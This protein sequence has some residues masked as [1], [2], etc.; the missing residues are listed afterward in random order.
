MD[1][2][3]N[4][5]GPLQSSMD[6]LNGGSA[7]LVTPVK[8]K[9]HEQ[10]LEIQHKHQTETHEPQQQ[11]EEQQH[12]LMSQNLEQQHQQRQQHQ[13]QPLPPQQQH[14][15][16][17]AQHQVQQHQQKQQH[18]QQPQRQ[19]QQQ[20]KLTSQHLKQQQQQQQPQ[21]QQQQQQQHDTMT[22]Q[23]EQ[24]HQQQ[25]QPQQQQQQQQQHDTM[26][27]QL[28]QQQQQQQQQQKQQQQWQQ[29]KQQQQQQRQLMSGASSDDICSHQ[30]F[31]QWGMS[32]RLTRE[33]MHMLVKQGFHSQESLRLLTPEVM[34]RVGNLPLEQE[35]RLKQVIQTSEKREKVNDPTLDELL[36]AHTE[37]I[38]DTN[39]DTQTG[40]STAKVYLTQA[41]GEGA[42]ALNIV[43]F[44][45]GVNS[46]TGIGVDGLSSVSPHQWSAANARIMYELMTQQ[47]WSAEKLADYM[48]YI[49]KIAELAICYDWQSVL[50]YDYQYRQLQAT[51]KFPWASDTPHLHQTVLKEQKVM[52]SNKFL[53][54]KT[55][56]TRPADPCTGK[57]ICIKFNTGEC[58]FGGKC[59]YIHICSKCFSANH[60]LKNHPKN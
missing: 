10:Q 44:I 55:K 15:N 1:D 49:V 41:K 47:K 5:W 16:L 24:Q 39:T 45:P 46:E 50:A 58:S 2:L 57:E 35:L 38:M 37:P 53:Q 40:Y 23:L 29:Q 34:P 36:G 33:T 52:G 26:S 18:K 20:H 30:P 13:Q 48:A 8:H 42:A 22:Q 4:L 9:Q 56:F 19:E 31:V 14:Y 25:Q 6:I 3:Q 11:Q 21:Q 54:R 43:D 60:N 59:R 12:R 32:Q 51:L 17:M 27:Q 7:T 28:E